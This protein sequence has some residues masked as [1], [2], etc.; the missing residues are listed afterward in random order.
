MPV[1]CGPRNPRSVFWLRDAPL[2]PERRLPKRQQTVKVES[3]HR[4]HTAPALHALGQRVQARCL[5]SCDRHGWQERQITEPVVQAVV[6]NR[7]FRIDVL[8]FR[9]P[10]E[11][12]PLVPELVDQLERNALAARENPPIRNAIE[13][14]IVKMAT[15]LYQPTKPSGEI[16]TEGLF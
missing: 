10:R 12:R 7:R 11:R 1:C 16:R 3:V 15:R 9:E 6:A 2:V 14:G 5:E 13:A 8:R 4:L